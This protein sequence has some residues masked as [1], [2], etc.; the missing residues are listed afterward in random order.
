MKKK[1]LTSA[2]ILAMCG[3]ICAQGLVAAKGSFTPPCLINGLS[4]PAKAQASK[5]FTYFGKTGVSTLGEEAAASYDCAIFVPAEYAGKQIDKVEFLLCNPAVLIAPKMWISSTLP[6]N[7]ESA[8]GVCLDITNPVGYSED[9]TSVTLPSSYTIP[10][11]GCYVGYSFSVADASEYD[12]KYPVITGSTDEPSVNGGHFLRAS[13]TVKEWTNMYGTEFGNLTTMVTISGEYP[14]HGATVKPAFVKESR[15]IKDKGGKVTLTVTGQGT[16]PISSLDY[17]VTNIAKNCSYDMHAE[18]GDDAIAFDTQATVSL[19]I[20]AEE[21]SGTAKMMIVINKVNGE[22]NA[23]TE[24]IS[25]QGTLL[26]LAAESKRMIVEEEFTAT[27][28]GFCPRGITGLRLMKERYPD[29]FIGIAAHDKMGKTDP[30]KISAYNTIVM[31]YGGNLPSATLNRTSTIDPYYGSD[32][33]YTQ[34]M[35]ITNDYEALLDIPVECSV[36]VTP[37]WDD[38]DYTKIRVSTNITFQYNS[39]SAPFAISYVVVADSLTGSTSGWYQVNNFSNKT[40]LF[41]DV[42]MREWIVKPAIIKDMVYDHVSIAGIGVAN[43]LKGVIRAPIIEGV[44][45][46]HEYVIDMS[47]N[48]LM[49]DKSKLKVV[50]MVMSTKTGEIINADEKALVYD[51]PTGIENIGEV[52]RKITETARYTIDGRRAAGKTRGLSIVRMSDGSVKKVITK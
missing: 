39:S 19:P 6:A 46:N 49:Q 45:Q 12:G 21:E 43:G 24:D 36:D 34:P 8:D 18:L 23:C 52:S 22:P 20:K 40:S 47:E 32:N 35:Y 14:E 51:G 50:A 33:S 42:N 31:N 25:S 48:K 26:T 38:A 4:A 9:F 1:I 28:C 30:M 13:L 37:S 15:A 29:S 7:A 17:T 5:V 11:G 27:G 10:Q 2:I 16:T 44:A 3:T 41:D